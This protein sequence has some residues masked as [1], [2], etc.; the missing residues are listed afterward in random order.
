MSRY[1]CDRCNNQ[2]DGRPKG[3]VENGLNFHSN[4]VSSAVG[5][6]EGESQQKR[7][8]LEANQEDKNENK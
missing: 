1:R 6:D 8:A 4:K 7:Y 5:A 2:R 3:K